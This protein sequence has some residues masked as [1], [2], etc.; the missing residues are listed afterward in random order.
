MGEIFLFYFILGFD[1][2]YKGISGQ[3]L[4]EKLEPGHYRLQ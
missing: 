1:K 4:S 3:E 2:V